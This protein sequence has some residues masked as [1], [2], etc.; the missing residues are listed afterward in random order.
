[1][2]LGHFAQFIAV[3]SCAKTC[4]I[5]ENLLSVSDPIS[6]P[7]EMLIHVGA[8]VRPPAL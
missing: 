3:C 2:A 7:E 6:G 8:L 4:A 1:L 5:G